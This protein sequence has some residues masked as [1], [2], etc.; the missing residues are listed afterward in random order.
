MN[1]ITKDKLIR[2]QEAMSFSGGLKLF[3]CSETIET[4]SMSEIKTIGSSGKIKG[5][6]L[7]D[8]SKREQKEHDLTFHEWICK[9]KRK[10]VQKY[11]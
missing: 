10:R 2:K 3:L 1:Q 4:I 8:Y 5:K 11:L 6:Y 9:E 7:M